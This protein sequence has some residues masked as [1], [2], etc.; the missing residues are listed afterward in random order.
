MSVAGPQ[1]IRRPGQCI[2]L[3]KAV[4][5]GWRAHWA[6]LAGQLVVSA[7]GGLAPV[8]AAGLLRLIVD[9]ITSGRPH[10]SVVP[11]IA[12]LA[13][14]GC[15]STAMPA[16]GQYLAAQA[17][18]ALERHTLTELF[19][20]VGRL[21]GLRTLESPDFQDRLRLAQQAGVTGPGQVVTCA[22]GVGQSALTLGGFLVTLVVISPVMALIVVAAAIPAVFAERAVAGG[23][24]Q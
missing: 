11:L 13:V 23:E 6:A 7:L 4:V 10:D 2:L 24:W 16:A 12:E 9:A 17:G 14:V 18:R 3:W 19:T 21:V 8:A 1:N 5:L 15:L 20:A 22:M